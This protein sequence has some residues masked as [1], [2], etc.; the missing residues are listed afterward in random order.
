MD[1]P[2]AVAHD[3][4]SP[5]A[6]G[7]IRVPLPSTAV[8]LLVEPCRFVERSVF[9]YRSV[10]SCV[11]ESDFEHAATPVTWSIA[12]PSVGDHVLGAV[13]VLA[14]APRPL[15]ACVVLVQPAIALV[16]VPRFGS[17]ALAAFAVLAVAPAAIAW[18]L[19]IG[20]RR[21]RTPFLR[22]G[23][24]SESGTCGRTRTVLNPPSS[25]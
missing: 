10:R 13:A 23:Q 16:A 12:F 1:V 6:G 11:T 20:Q 8:S 2:F 18:W 19:A 3:S 15:W 4:S 25:T 5:V 9:W 21:L 14:V 22:R 7:S 24:P 17:L